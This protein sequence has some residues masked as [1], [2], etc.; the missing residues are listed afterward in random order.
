MIKLDDHF[1]R[2][3]EGYVMA[4]QALDQ[5]N[6]ARNAGLKDQANQLEAGFEQ[7]II[8]LRRSGGMDASGFNAYRE[9]AA[10]L[11]RQTADVAKEQKTASEIDFLT[12]RFEVLSKEANSAG[13]KIDPGRIQAMSDFLNSGQTG[14]ASTMLS[15]ISK[16]ITDALNLKREG[17]EKLSTE[18]A[19]TM[20]ELPLNQKKE[21]TNLVDIKLASGEVTSDALSDPSNKLALASE[22]KM[23]DQAK[24]QAREVFNRLQSAQEL[25][26]NA[27]YMGEFGDAPSTNWLQSMFASGDQAATEAK[28]EKLKGGDLAEG[29]KRIKEE[30]GTASGMAVE[31]TKALQA[32]IND[33]KLNLSPK[34]A[35]KALRKIVDSAR[36]TLNR[37]GVDQELTSVDGTANVLSNKEKYILEDE[38][39]YFKALEQSKVELPLGAPKSQSIDQQKLEQE[40]L[41]KAEEARKQTEALKAAYPSAP[42]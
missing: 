20:R 26:S 39:A 31:E 16:P 32:S 27:E 14:Q 33:L 18:A 17:A 37:L 35:E 29:M 25:L 10:N 22:A 13:I 42:K 41:K 9:Q 1:D 30:T 11:L 40:K 28:V 21:L 23:R 3:T 15:D 6:A 4:S 5:I 36:F 2:G 8:N 38:R 12:K 7:S 19:K 24:L 34:E